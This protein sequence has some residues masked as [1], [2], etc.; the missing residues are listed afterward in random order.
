[1]PKDGIE[2]TKSIL[3]SGDVGK[4]VKDYHLRSTSA[5]AAKMKKEPDIPLPGR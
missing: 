3:T 1:M 5:V 2:Y 4:A